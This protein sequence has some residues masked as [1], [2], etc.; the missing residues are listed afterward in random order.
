M[1]RFSLEFLSSH[2]TLWLVLAPVLIALA[3]FVYYRTLAPLERPTRT[4]LR[5]LRGLAFLIVLFALAEPI[6]TLVLPEP[7]K[8]GLAVLVDSSASMALPAGVSG[9]RSRADEA[10]EIVGAI[11]QKLSGRYRLDWFRFSSSLVPSER[12]PVGD[13]AGGPAG[14]KEPREQAGSSTA[15]AADGRGEDAG[16]NTAI[17]T[18]LERI[19]SR[20]GARPVG[21]VLLVSDGANTSGIDPIGAAR[22]TGVPVFPIRVGAP[23]APPDARILQVRANP[24]AFAGEPA[25]VEVEIASAGLAGKTVEIRVEDQGRLLATQNVT[26]EAG[27]EREQSIRLD[28]R[29][30]APGMRRWEIKLAGANDPVPENDSR[31]VAVQAVSYT[32]LTL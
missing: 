18:A 29:P 8:P 24:V 12:P 20:R 15:A 4:V 31:S 27:E 23:I 16:G 10:K 22:A 5:V 21:A 26:L 2:A 28:V 17:G 6:L 30:G 3:I 13:E 25:P 7:G 1:S 32:H 19:A 11:E 14:S 9:E